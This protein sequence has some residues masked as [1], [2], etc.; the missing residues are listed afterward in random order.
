MFF[1][2][3][4]Y[5]NNFKTNI[6]SELSEEVFAAD[7]YSGE[8]DNL[9]ENKLTFKGNAKSQIYISFLNVNNQRK[10]TGNIRADIYFACFVVTA[11]DKKMS[12]FSTKGVEHTHK[13]IKFIANKNN[14]TNKQLG[15]N[16]IEWRNIVNNVDAQKMYNIHRIVFK[17]EGLLEY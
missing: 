2:V 12:G 1:D 9:S 7:I 8:L 13:I 17:I 3:A 15:T 5:L 14:L 10:L 11:V 16:I 4:E 6:L